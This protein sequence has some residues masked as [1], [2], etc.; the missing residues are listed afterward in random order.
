MAN[1]I[2]IAK[3][4]SKATK[5][6]DAAKNK[7]Y[8]AAPPAPRGKKNSS[9]SLTMPTAG[10]AK[11]ANRNARVKDFMEPTTKGKNKNWAKDANKKTLPTASNSRRASIKEA[12]FNSRMEKHPL[13]RNTGQSS[14]E[15]KYR[16]NGGKPIPT[17]KRGK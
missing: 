1:P 4:I 17:K 2:K 15:G 9:K 10:K 5:A 11:A 16:A 6:R 12:N 8:S 13:V 14:A 7:A 3:V